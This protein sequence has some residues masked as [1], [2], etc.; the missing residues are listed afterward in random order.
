MPGTISMFVWERA[1][2]LRRYEVIVQRDLAR[3]TE[4]MTAAVPG[5]DDRGAEQRQ[6]DRALRHRLAAR[7][8]ST[9]RSTSPPATSRRPTTSST[10][11]RLQETHGEQPGAAA[12]ALRRSEPQRDD[13]ARRVV[14]HQPD[15]LSRTP[16]AGR[17]PQQFAA[18]ASRS[19]WTKANSDFGS[20]VTSAEGKFTFSDFLN[21]FLFRHEVRPRRGDQ[22]AADQGAVPEPRRAEPGRRE[23]QGSE[24]PRRRR[25]PDSGRAGLR[26]QRRDHACS[27]RNSASA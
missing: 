20:D 9:R 25:V 10:C 2:A 11:C 14:L 13:R 4:Q 27:S 17:R 19:A 8:S 26:R 7:T 24:L 16:S 6:G 12:R 18:P 5:R 22:G 21:L 3:L 15:R 1:G 23:R